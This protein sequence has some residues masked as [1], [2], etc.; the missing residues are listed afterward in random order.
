MPP[1]CCICERKEGEDGAELTVIH[2]DSCVV[3]IC[4]YPC[5]YLAATI[6]YEKCRCCGTVATIPKDRIPCGHAL[7]MHS[8]ILFV[9]S[10]KFCEIMRCSTSQQ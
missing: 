7:G 2:T 1:Q 8:F 6:C 3:P 9:E 10:C 4:K 5:L